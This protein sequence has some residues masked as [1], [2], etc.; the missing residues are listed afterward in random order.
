[1]AAAEVELRNSENDAEVV[2]EYANWLGELA[3]ARR[4]LRG[5]DGVGELFASGAAAARALCG[6]DRAVVLSVRT[7]VLTAAES[8]ALTDPASDAL[9]RRVR[10]EPVEIPVGSREAAIIRDPDAPAAGRLP[11]VLAAA[12]DLNHFALAAVAPDSSPLALLLV[13]REDGPV[14]KLDRARVDSFAAALSLALERILIRSRVSELAR[15]FRQLTASTQALA[16][17]TLQAPITLPA[18]HGHGPAFPGLAPSASLS[19]GDLSEILSARELDIAALLAEGLSNRAIAEQLVL[20]PETVKAHVARILRKVG[21][22]NRTEAVFH[23]VRLADS[24]TLVGK[25]APRYLRGLFDRQP[26]HHQ[27]RLRQVDVDVRA[28]AG[29]PRPPA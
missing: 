29:R 22:A 7:R 18:D 27:C 10:S 2:V 9:R 17:E 4:A 8:D 1:M 25:W 12:L 24:R 14:E 11:S 13:D 19:G 16:A 5:C 28:R 21:A 6:F 3:A 26:E 15:E 20:S 23:L